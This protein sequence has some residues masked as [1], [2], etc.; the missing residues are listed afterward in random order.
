MGWLRDALA[1]VVPK[2]DFLR[3]LSLQEHGKEFS[4]RVTSGQD[5][6]GLRL[7]GGRLGGGRGK[8][9]DAVFVLHDSSRDAALVVLV[10]LKGRDTKKALR[11]IRESFDR[12]CARNPDNAVHAHPVVGR[13][14]QRLPKGTGHRERVLGVVVARHGLS[15]RQQ[16]RARNARDGLVVVQRKE[17]VHANVSE[18]YEAMATRRSV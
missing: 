12:L 14:R 8:S 2:Q 4:I 18:L 11:Q 5:A 1:T 16:D 10:E 15:L 3:G 6:V 9:C 13:F 17:R 7:D